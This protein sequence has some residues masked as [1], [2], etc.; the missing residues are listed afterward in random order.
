MHSTGRKSERKRVESRTS[1]GKKA[2]DVLHGNDFCSACACVIAF[3]LLIVS[4][5]NIHLNGF[6]FEHYEKFITH[7]IQW[8]RTHRSYERAKNWCVSVCVLYCDVVVCVKLFSSLCSEL[9]WIIRKFL[10]MHIHTLHV[11][12]GLTDFHFEISPKNWLTNGRVK[13]I[14]P[15]DVCVCVC[16]SLSCASHPFI[17]IRI[18]LRQCSFSQKFSHTRSH[19]PRY[20]AHT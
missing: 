8:C 1:D 17:R 15:V 16:V 11:P 19:W 7:R 10:N 9:K 13:N 6:N 12:F 3:Y 2:M 5:W 4:H 20:M 14:Y 18:W